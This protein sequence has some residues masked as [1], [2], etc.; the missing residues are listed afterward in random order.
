MGAWEDKPHWKKIFAKDIS[1]NGPN[2]IW[3]FPDGSDGKESTC[4]AGDPSSIP[5]SGRSTGEGNVSIAEKISWTE[6]PGRLQSMRLQKVGH[7]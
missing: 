7:D 4:N 6:D 1:I 5:G 2:L 3:G